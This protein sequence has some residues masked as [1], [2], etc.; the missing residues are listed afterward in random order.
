MNDR[1]DKMFELRCSF[2]KKLQDIGKEM[3]NWPVDVADKRSQLFIKDVLYHGMEELFEALRELKNAKKH[4]QTDVPEFDRDHF[5]EEM[6]DAFNLFLEALV[7]VGISPQE[8]FV[9]Y[10]KKDLIINKRIDEKY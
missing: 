2:M 5:L 7:L 3:P 1:L 6:V 4:R 8:F 10:V 9:A